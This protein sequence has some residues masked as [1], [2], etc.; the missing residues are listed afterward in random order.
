MRSVELLRDKVTD[1]KKYP[2]CIPAVR[3]LKSLELHPKVTFFVGENGSGKSTLIE[4][5]AVA[6]GFNAEGGSRSFKFATR[7]S[8]SD[9]HQTLRL[10]RGTRR[11]KTGYFL[12]AESFFNVASNIEA[13]DEDPWGGP[14]II[15]SHGGRSLHEQS[16]GESF[17]ALVQHRFGSNGLFILDEPEAALSPQR[18]LVLLRLIDELVQKRGS[19]IIVATHS[20]IVLAYPDAFIYSLDGPAGPVQTP[21]EA[22]EHFALTR[23]FLLNHHRYVGRLLAGEESPE[24]AT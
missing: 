19:Q 5:I 12:R 3:H 8:E 4:G 23:D 22:T 18:Q 20:P 10:V 15:D 13:L 14:P 9:L 16:H 11:P 21:Y 6:A 1:F 17:L 7:R 24:K 2:F